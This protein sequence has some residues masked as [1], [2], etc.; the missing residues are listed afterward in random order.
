MNT[1]AEFCFD[2][3]K[4][5]LDKSAKREDF[6]ISKDDDLDLCEGC[7]EYKPVVIRYKRFWDFH[8]FEIISNSAKKLR[9]K[10]RKGD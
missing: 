7:G 6:I 10:L 3:Y 2:C 1:I 4:K 5:H 9:D 8:I